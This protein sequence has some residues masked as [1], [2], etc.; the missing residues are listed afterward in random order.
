MA[1]IDDLSILLPSASV[2]ILT[3]YIRKAVTL[4]TNY[5][6]LDTAEIDETDW[7]TGIV[8]TIEPIDPTITYADACIEYVTLCWN[9]R[10][11]EGLIQFGQGSRSGTYGNALYDSVK[12]LLPAPYA[13]MVDTRR[14]H[15]C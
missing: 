14:H 3:L 8:T 1:L 15:V 13:I 5:L 2:P 7:Y 12:A 4:I 6:N 11:N 9:K 10:G